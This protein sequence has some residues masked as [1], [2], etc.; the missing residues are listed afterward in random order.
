MKFKEFLN[1]LQNLPD[2]K[3]K[4]ILW[5]VVGILGITMGIFWINGAINNFSKIGS[6]VGQIKLPEI[7]TP[8]TEIPIT[9]TTVNKTADWKTY[10][11]DSLEQCN[12]EIKYPADWSAYTWPLHFVVAPGGLVIEQDPQT[13]NGCSFQM[14]F[15]KYSEKEK[16][17]YPVILSDG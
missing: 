7:Q 2:N 14:T 15:D 16:Y 10:N 6:S 4:I 17:C 3:K 12:F 9:E 8:K 5:V 13:H 11:V 1:K